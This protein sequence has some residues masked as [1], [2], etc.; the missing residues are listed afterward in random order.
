MKTQI[1]K[2]HE[3]A[4]VTIEF[5]TPFLVSSGRADFSQDAVPLREMNGL[6]I[7]PG[8]SIAGVLRDAYRAEGEDEREIFGDPGAGDQQSGSMIWISWG[9]IHNAA[10][11]AVEGLLEGG[12]F[13]PVLLNALELDLRDHVRINHRG[14]V[15]ENGKFDET[16]VPA[17]HRFTFDMM[18]EDCSDKGA[19]GQLLGL[20][21][22]DLT[23]IGRSGRRGLGAFKVHR[24]QRR[25]FDMTDPTQAEAFRDLPKELGESIDGSMGEFSPIDSE[26]EWSTFSLTLEPQELWGFNGAEEWKRPTD[27]EEDGPPKFNPVREKRVV[28]NGQTGSVSAAKMYVPGSSVKGAIAHRVAFH[29]NVLEKNFADEMTSID[30]LRDVCGEGNGAVRELFGSMKNGNGGAAGK[31]FIDDIAL[32]D[33]HH[34]ALV[35]VMHNSLDRFT[36]GTRQGFLFEERVINGGNPLTLRIQV[37]QFEKMAA[38]TKMAFVRALEDLTN[39]R[40]ALGAGASRGHGT[41]RGDEATLAQVKKW[42]GMEEGA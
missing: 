15:D 10:D 18:I 12:V 17:G 22:S 24:V 4:R 31:V 21:D 14:A 3:I 16:V 6:P 29:W 5:T 23:R 11:Q 27:K 38:N 41:F 19:M 7:I 39:G 25:S 36:G 28:W 40:L 9:H 33:S 35:K 26:D 30:E 13:D 8:T 1:N 2:A 20:L 34:S 32:D 37:R 42:N